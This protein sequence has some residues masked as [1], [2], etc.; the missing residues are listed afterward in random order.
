MEKPIQVY[1]TAVAVYLPEQWSE[2][3]A[4]AQDAEKQIVA[5]G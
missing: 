3:L 1:L 5:W 2:L 4:T